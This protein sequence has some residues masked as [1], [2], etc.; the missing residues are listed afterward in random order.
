[1]FTQTLVKNGVRINPAALESP[2]QIGRVERRQATLKHMFNKVIQET[3]AIGNEQVDMALAESVTAINE[4]SRHCEFAL[5]QWVFARFP[6][7]PVTPGDETER[8]EIGALHIFPDEPMAS[9]MQ[10]KYRQ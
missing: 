7:K 6:R 2:Q 3:K 5:V 8:F 4:M 9:A 10:S 1:M